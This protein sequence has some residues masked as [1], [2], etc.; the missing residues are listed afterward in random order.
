MTGFQGQD[1]T[2]AER[3]VQI[4]FTP[5]S[6]LTFA[7]SYNIVNRKF[8]PLI[9]L[10]RSQIQFDK[11][12][13][14]I[15]FRNTSGQL[16]SLFVAGSK[17]SLISTAFF[18]WNSHVE[19]ANIQITGA[20]CLA[21]AALAVLNSTVIFSGTNTFNGN[22]AFRVGGTVYSLDYSIITLSG[23]NHFE[24]NYARVSGGAI[25]VSN[26]LNHQWFSIFL[27]NR[28][29]YGNAGAIGLDESTLLLERNGSLHNYQ[30]EFCTIDRGS[31]LYEYVQCTNKR[32]IDHP[33]EHS[34]SRF[35]W[36]VFF[37]C[38]LYII[39]QQLSSSRWSNLGSH[40]N[41][42]ITLFENNRATFDGGAIYIL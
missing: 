16:S 36:N 27:R 23:V 39:H 25:H 19:M 1:S 33:A 20:K 13:V 30:R 11:I 10:S 4:V 34:D 41:L 29:E 21:S 8:F 18:C 3:A 5:G 31:Y 15:Q 38:N 35:I 42:S 14:S 37:Q 22:F 24:G 2:S 40:V 9:L 6:N 17:S 26:S 32:T 7:A 28:V 12:F